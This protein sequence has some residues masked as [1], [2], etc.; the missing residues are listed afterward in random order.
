MKFIIS[1]FLLV[2]LIATT[3]VA[4]DTLRGLGMDNEHRAAATAKN[5]EV[6]YYYGPLDWYSSEFQCKF[7]EAQYLRSKPTAKL[8]CREA[9]CCQC[10][11]SY[12]AKS[13]KACNPNNKKSGCFPDTPLLWYDDRDQCM[14]SYVQ[15]YG[16]S[17]ATA[18]SC[19]R[20]GGCCL[21]PGSSRVTYK[22][23]TFC[24]P[25]P[26]TPAPTPFPSCFD[27]PCPTYEETGSI[28]FTSPGYPDPYTDGSACS[29]TLPQ[30]GTL[31][32]ETFDLEF[33]S[34]DCPCDSVAFPNDTRFCGTDSAGLDGAT[35]NQDDTICFQTDGFVTGAGFQIC[36]D[37]S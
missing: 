14:Q 25:P 17:Q 20:E 12:Y 32:V 35:L 7:Y 10:S 11:A 34:E 4:D 28:C 26:P 16:Y 5:K 23:D 18:D 22:D 3:I 27:I 29:F 2:P 9:G 1:R 8:C 31:R 30:A 15:D 33:C 37:Y 6:C 36:V 19:C 21:C 24:D 13:P